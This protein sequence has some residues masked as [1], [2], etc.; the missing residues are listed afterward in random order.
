MRHN[1]RKIL[2]KLKIKNKKKPNPLRY[3]HTK[4][5]LDYIRSRGF[6]SADAMGTVGVDRRGGERLSKTDKQ[7]KS[8]LAPTGKR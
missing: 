3:M 4:Y 8:I 2:N 6:S 5:A 1:K 7:F